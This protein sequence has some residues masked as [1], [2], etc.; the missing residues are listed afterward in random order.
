MDYQDPILIK[1]LRGQNS[2]IRSIQ[3]SPDMMQAVSGS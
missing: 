1:S 3:L 2:Q